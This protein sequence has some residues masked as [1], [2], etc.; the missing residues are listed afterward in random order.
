MFPVAAK[1]HMH[2]NPRIT[3]CIITIQSKVLC[4]QEN[5]TYLLSKQRQH[6]SW[7]T[8]AAQ[9]R[10]IAFIPSIKR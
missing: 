9:R 3:D 5:A 8:G 10:L 1:H 7:S 6:P 4:D 2:H